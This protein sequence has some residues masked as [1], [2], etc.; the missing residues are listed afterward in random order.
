MNGTV[1]LRYLLAAATRH[2]AGNDLDGNLVGLQ[3]GEQVRNV[4]ENLKCKFM[5]R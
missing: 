2:F 4:K 3:N 5:L 1:V